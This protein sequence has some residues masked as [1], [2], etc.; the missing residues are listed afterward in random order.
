MGSLGQSWR[1][2]GGGCQLH[3]HSAAQT[4]T[5]TPANTIIHHSYIAHSCNTQ[6]IGDYLV[7]ND[8]A[9]QEREITSNYHGGDIGHGS[10]HKMKID[11]MAHGHILMSQ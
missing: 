1:T 11:I 4:V 7:V 2:G 6:V 5:S 10:K 3:G 8:M 9:F